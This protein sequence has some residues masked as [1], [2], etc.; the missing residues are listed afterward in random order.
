MQ[1][2]ANTTKASS[3]VSSAIMRSAPQRTSA[4]DPG[5]AATTCA[6]HLVDRRTGLPQRINGSLLAV[7][8]KTPRE[9]VAEILRNR[10]ASRWEA[11]VD[12][13]TTQEAQR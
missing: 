5:K 8:T 2:A 4:P 3:T 6:V 10:D 11:R 13:L 1:V 7:F 9:T 12:P